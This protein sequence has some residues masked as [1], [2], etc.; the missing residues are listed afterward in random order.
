MGEVKD[1][2]VLLEREWIRM[3]KECLG[4]DREGPVTRHPIMVEMSMDTDD[5]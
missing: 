4:H 5:I 2:K 3:H 1:I